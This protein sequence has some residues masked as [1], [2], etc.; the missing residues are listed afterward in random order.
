MASK[1]RLDIYNSAHT[2]AAALLDTTDAYALENAM[3]TSFND[4][5]QDPKDF[6]LWKSIFN[7]RL[8]AMKQM[9]AMAAPSASP[10]P[11]IP[12]AMAVPGLKV[13]P[14]ALPGKG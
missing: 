14:A 3:L 4:G 6:G 7:E 8:V 12:A 11:V 10:A 5:S 13:V 9:R 1:T 2:A